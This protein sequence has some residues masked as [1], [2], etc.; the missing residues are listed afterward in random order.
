MIEVRRDYIVPS[1]YIH[2]INNERLMDGGGSE[3]TPQGDPGNK[4]EEGSGAGN[5]DQEDL[6]EGTGN[7]KLFD[8]I[9][10]DAYDFMQD[11]EKKNWYD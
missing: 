1:V 5:G 3:I 9:D 10:I 8:L 2:Q 11:Y 4:Q 6:G 7:A